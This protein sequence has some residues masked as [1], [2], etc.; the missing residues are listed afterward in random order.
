MALRNKLLSEVCFVSI[1]HYKMRD[2]IIFSWGHQLILFF[3]MEGL[4]DIVN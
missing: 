2:L 4:S 1:I 3:S